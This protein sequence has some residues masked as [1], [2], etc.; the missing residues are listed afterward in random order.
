MSVT[1]EIPPDLAARIAAQAEEQGISPDAYLRLLIE[2]HETRAQA[3]TALSP[4]ERAR[5]WREWAESH[6]ADTPL[7]SDEAISRDSIYRER[8]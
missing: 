8:G 2:E 1:L 7:L 6:N 4:Q 3:G 5:L